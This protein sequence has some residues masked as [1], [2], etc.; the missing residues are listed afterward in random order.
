MGSYDKKVLLCMLFDISISSPLSSDKKIKLC[1]WSFPK[2]FFSKQLSKRGRAV[3]KKIWCFDFK[4]KLQQIPI[5][6]CDRYLII[7]KSPISS[8][9]WRH[10]CRP[11]VIFRFTFSL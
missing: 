3:W 2:I 11:F 1:W 6:F 4:P 10:G 8:P 7:S 9:S 5:R